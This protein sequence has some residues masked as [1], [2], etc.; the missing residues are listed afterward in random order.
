MAT[1]SLRLFWLMPLIASKPQS[2]SWLSDVLRRL[3]RTE[4]FAFLWVQI[5]FLWHAKEKLSSVWCYR[6]DLFFLFLFQVVST[7]FYSFSLPL[8]YSVSLSHFFFQFL[9]HLLDLDFIFFS[10]D[11]Y[12]NSRD[13]NIVTVSMTQVR[14]Q[15]TV[16]GHVPMPVRLNT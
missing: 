7:C 5:E 2:E 16:P 1:V 14:R 9:L 4:V 3:S 11:F 12:A 6:L 8:P 13:P 10:H 15:N